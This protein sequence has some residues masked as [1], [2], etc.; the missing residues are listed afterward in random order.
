M[1]IGNEVLSFIG[2][3]TLHIYVLHGVFIAVTR[4]E[5]SKIVLNLYEVSP[6]IICIVVGVLVPLSIY[7]IC[8]KCNLDFIFTPKKFISK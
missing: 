2:R 5:L 7:K 4:I 3:G 8:I 6:F 1:R